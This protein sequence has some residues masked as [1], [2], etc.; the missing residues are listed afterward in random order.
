MLDAGAFIGRKALPSVN[1]GLAAKLWG[2]EARSWLRPS[3]MHAGRWTSSTTSS[4]T[5]GVSAS[6]NIVDDVTKECLGAIPDPLSRD[7]EFPAEWC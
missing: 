1:G 5:A 2:P 3:P 4:L 7:G 6:S